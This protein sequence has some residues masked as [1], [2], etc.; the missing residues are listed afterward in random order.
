MFYQL[1]LKRRSHLQTK[2]KELEKKVFDYPKENLVLT[3][4]GSYSKWYKSDGKTSTY[5][6]KK[7]K[8]FA[9]VLAHKKYASYLLEELLQE[10]T[11]IDSFLTKYQS[12][13]RKSEL[14]LKD[15]SFLKLFSEHSSM[16]S[17]TFQKWITEEYEKNPKY[18]EHLNHKCLSGEYARSKSEV[19]IANTLFTHHIPYRYECALTL[20]GITF[21][22]DFTILNPSTSQI[23][24]W[25]HFGMMDTP[26]YCDQSFNKLKQFCHHGI[27]PSINLITTYETKLHPINSEQI[28][29][30]VSDY[31]E[32]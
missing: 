14:L 8:A 18:P 3:H 20:G 1:L 15:E 30:I 4:Y 7:E 31:F 27:I 11:L 6:P 21:Y 12:L 10:Q 17:N 5:I 24:Y 16:Q 19:I 23:I 25:E 22:P 9:Q 32:F 29:R 13:P 28:E 2:I 26:S